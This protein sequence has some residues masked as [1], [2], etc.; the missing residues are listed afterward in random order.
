MLPTTT[1]TDRSERPAHPP[2]RKEQPWCFI[3]ARR[4]DEEEFGAML[5]ADAEA[6]S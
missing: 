6:S 5:V 2:I 4:D 1:D 3:V